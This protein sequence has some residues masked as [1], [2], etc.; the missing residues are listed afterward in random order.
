MLADQLADD[1]W[2]GLDGLA[3]RSAP[4]TGQMVSF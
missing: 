4:R 2:F 1:D 3:G